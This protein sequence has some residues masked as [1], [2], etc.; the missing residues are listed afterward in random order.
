[1]SDIR[2]AFE[3]HSMKEYGA[4]GQ[5]DDGRY[6]SPVTQHDW[7]VWQAAVQWAALS[8]NGGEAEPVGWVK[9]INGEI[10]FIELDGILSHDAKTHGWRAVTLTHPAPPSVAVPDRDAV[11]AKLEAAQKCHPNAV[12]HLISEAV[13]MLAAPSPDHS[14]DA[15]KVASP[16]RQPAQ[17]KWLLRLRGGYQAVRGLYSRPG[18]RGY[19]N[20]ISEAGRFTEQEAK[21]SE[22]ACPDKYR[23]IPD[24]APDHIPDAGKVVASHWK[25]AKNGQHWPHIG[26][27]YLIKM[28]GVLQHEIYEF[29]QADDGFGGGEYF[30]D[31]DDLDEAAPFDPENDEWLPINQAGIP[32]APD[33]DHSPDAGRMIPVHEDTPEMGMPVIGY[34]PDWIDPDFNERG[35]RECFTYGDATVPGGDWHTAKWADGADQ[36]ETT[37]EAPTH[38]FPIGPCLDAVSVIRAAQCFDIAHFEGWDAALETGNLP[39]IRDIWQRRVSWAETYIN[40]AMNAP[41]LRAAGDDKEGA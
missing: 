28:K 32:A 31:R 27:K 14:G 22:A 40:E 23:A 37:D 34:N 7:K 20:N 8:A 10:Q 13:E 16:E 38:W 17:H 21:E 33:P 36:Y 3:A 24:T 26:A 11:L 15:N 4:V 41:C 5:R 19:T 2:E 1:M 35:Y 12:P 18:H 9:W 25:S 39:A 6:M 29:D 30:W